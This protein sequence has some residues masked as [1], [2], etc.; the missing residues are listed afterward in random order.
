[1]PD[2]D[3][4]APDDEFLILDSD[5]TQS[6]AIARILAG[7]NLVVKGPPGTGK[8]Q[9]ISNLIASLAARGKTVLFVAEKRAAIDAVTKRLTQREL[10]ALVLDVHGGIGTRRQFAARMKEAFA[11]VEQSATVDASD[12]HD[13]LVCDRGELREASDVLHLLRTPWGVSLYDAFCAALE[14]GEETPLRLTGVPLVAATGEV[15]KSSCAR[16]REL[17]ELGGIGA[18]LSQG[19]WRTATIDTEAEAQRAQALLVTLRQDALRLVRRRIQE[20]TAVTGY[21][22]SAT[23]SMFVTDV[24]LIDRA[25]ALLARYEPDVWSA[26]LDALQRALIAG[27]SG[28]FAHWFRLAISGSYRR[29]NRELKVHVLADRKPSCPPIVDALELGIVRDSWRPA[30]QGGVPR[31]HPDIAGLAADMASAFDGVNEF[32]KLAGDATLVDLPL[33]ELDARMTAFAADLTTLAKL[34]RIHTLRTELEA[35]GFGPAVDFLTREGADR[36]TP[37]GAERVVQG[38]WARSIIDAIVLGDPRLARLTSARLDTARLRFAA[39]DRRHIDTTAQ[40][41]RRAAALNAMERRN[42]HREA[43]ALLEK[44]ANLKSRHKPVRELI[45]QTMPVLLGMKP[46]WV[47]S[48]LM[49]SQVLPQRPVFDVVIFDEASQIMPHDAVAAIARGRQ[50][51]V[52]GDE[53]QLPPTAFFGSVSAEDEA[54]EEA[55]QLD[56]LPPDDGGTRGYESILDALQP[57]LPWRQLGWHYRSKDE[58][59]IAFS[60]AHIYGGSLTTFPGAWADPPVSHVLVA[61]DPERPTAKGS[62]P[63]EVERVVELVLEHARTRPTESLGVIA[64]GIEH[65]LRIDALLLARRRESPETEAFFDESREERFFVKNLERVQGDERDAII[66]SIGYGKDA[67]GQLPYRFG[68]LLSEGGERRLNVAVTRAKRRM[69]LVS[70]FAHEDMAAGRSTAKGVELL[71]EYLRFAASGGSEVGS[72]SAVDH[73]L[74]AFELDVQRVLTERG[75]V[76]DAQHGCSG[77]RIDFVVRHPDQPGRYVLAV[78]CDGAAYHSSPAARDR[79]RLRQEHLERL[80]WSFHRIWSTDWFHDSAK[81]ADAVVTA[82]ERELAELAAP[83]VESV[84][85]EPDPVAAAIPDVVSSTGER[86]PRPWIEPGAPIT[87]YSPEQLV[88]IARWIQS[89]GRLRT[90]D[91]LMAEMRTVMGFSRRGSRI[92][93]ALAAAVAQLE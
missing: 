90:D 49:V 78:E 11:W 42:E 23:I 66:L 2:F 39:A 15:L 93:A 59:L 37:D 61:S 10:D 54:A 63:L 52:A 6:A 48:P 76:V 92:D 31:P 47:M 16:A 89:D 24:D 81:A 12:L 86:G 17:A 13:Q 36:A 33:D 70:S 87:A 62:S 71:R 43:N 60:N 21:A 9:T 27:K 88:A 26:D 84:V 38:M 50:L 57:L 79:D 53:R 18:A 69:T 91:A 74:N 22:P 25:T 29:A 55:E 14:S 30:A 68:P 19:V 80:G 64:M 41:V 65:A 51:V 45:D 72:A 7:E 82:F 1:M 46:C 8:S 3:A 44:Q 56:G 85:V 67:R 35:A 83:E 40:R 32:A 28:R 4:I 58:R 20:T 75:L 73:P 5:S 34:P 77:Y